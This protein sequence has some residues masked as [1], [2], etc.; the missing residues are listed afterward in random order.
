MYGQAGATHQRPTSG[1][2]GA[3]ILSGVAQVDLIVTCFVRCPPARLV[4]ALSEPV[5]L[6]ALWP[7]LVVTVTEDRGPLGTRW[8][9]AGALAGSCEIW[10]EQ[11]PAGT[12]VHAF[13]RTDPP[14]TVAR[15][16]RWAAR[17]ARRRQRQ[18][19]A[20]LWALKDTVEA[21]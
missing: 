13:L 6:A 5:T 21:G 8:S 16:R 14:S 2:A 9:V 18:L 20:A 1:L 11:V 4:P 7:R 12:V 17:E 10:L 15:S 19:S 3:G